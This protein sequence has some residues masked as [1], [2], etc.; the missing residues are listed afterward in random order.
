METELFE[1]IIIRKLSEQLSQIGEPI[2]EDISIDDQ[3]EILEARIDYLKQDS[4][5]CT[6]RIQ[7]MED[8]RKEI[9]TQLKGLKSLAKQLRSKATTDSGKENTL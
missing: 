3:L 2:M 5:M 9:Q 7:V 6:I 8:R 4:K 1:S